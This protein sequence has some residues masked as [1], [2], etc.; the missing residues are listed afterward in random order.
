MKTKKKI[1]EDK[2][3]LLDLERKKLKNLKKD[4]FQKKANKASKSDLAKIQA[5]INKIQDELSDG[6]P[7]NMVSVEKKDYFQKLGR[8]KVN[9]MVLMC[10][11]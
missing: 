10:I 11:N 8:E 6:P 3:A 9:M 2:S 1:W 4:F 5:S 7:G